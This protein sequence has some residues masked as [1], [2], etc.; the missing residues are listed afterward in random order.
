MRRAYLLA[1][2][3]GPI[4]IGLIPSIA[5]AQSRDQRRTAEAT[6]RAQDDVPAPGDAAAPSTP[7]RQSRNI[8]GVAMGA[9][10]HSME[11]SRAKE[12]EARAAK[13]RPSAPA[14]S[15]T[16]A[17]A[18]RGHKAGAVQEP[19]RVEPV[20]PAPHPESRDQLAAQPPADDAR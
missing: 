18:G 9:L 10:I 20:Q 5:L 17:D 15:T 3:I 4:F 7:T 1:I 19:A 16:S 14:Q 12:A 11:Q 6:E 13:G 8:L 2:F